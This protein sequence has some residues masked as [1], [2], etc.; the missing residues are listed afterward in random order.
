MFHPKHSLKIKAW[1]TYNN[2]SQVTID[3]NV[4]AGGG[5]QVINIYN[6]PNPFRD[7]T[8]FTFQHNYPGLIS[9]KIKVYT[10][11][12]RMIKEIDQPETNEKF[13]FIPWNGKDADGETLGNGVYIYKLVVTTE[14]GSNISSTGK[15]AVLK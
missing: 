13:V 9:A 11:A 15:L 2:S 10:V 1:D 7:G 14:E 4:M 3:F 5:L 6:Y 12:G 8:A